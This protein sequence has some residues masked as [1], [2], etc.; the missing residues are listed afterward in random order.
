MAKLQQNPKEPLKGTENG[1]LTF[2]I[3][4]HVFVPV[5]SNGTHAQ[6]QSAD[7]GKTVT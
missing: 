2:S 5:Y 7:H 6:L 1:C 4:T 3:L